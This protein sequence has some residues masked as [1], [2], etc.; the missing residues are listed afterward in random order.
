MLL[1]IAHR[2][3]R[4]QDVANTVDTPWKEFGV[5]LGLIQKLIEVFHSENGCLFLG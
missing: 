1:I 2:I 3:V 4:V 5:F